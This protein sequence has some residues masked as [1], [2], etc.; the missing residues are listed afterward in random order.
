MRKGQRH[1]EDAKKKMSA[2]RKGRIPW[3]KGLTAE[4]D[5]RVRK[6]AIA[7]RGKNLSKTHKRKISEANKGKKRSDETKRK[8]SE[9]HKGKNN[10]MYG[11]RHSEETKQKMSETRKA[12]YVLGETISWIKGK[13]QS[14]ET[15][16]KIG[17]SLKGRKFSV[18]HRK[19][20]SESGKGRIFSEEHRRNISEARK[21]K[22]SWNKGLHCS[23]ETKQKMR[24]ARLKRV[25]SKKNTSIEVALQRELDKRKIAYEKHIPVCGVCQPDIV[26]SSEKVAVFADGCY[27]HSKDFKDGKVWQRD[28]RQEEVLQE[29]G[30]IPIRFWGNEIRENVFECVDQIVSVLG[31]VQVGG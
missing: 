2:D 4:T 12:K 19:R 17:E 26:F 1:T 25:F 30:W 29:N 20:L 10:H 15:R 23:A 3:N 22:T 28:R 27:W 31:E 9:T 24:E 5:I 16:R 8:M 11:K 14:E 18:V 13:F 6:M 7:S 21:G